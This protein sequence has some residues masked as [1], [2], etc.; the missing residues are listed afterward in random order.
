MRI[1]I[2]EDDL[3]QL[4]L[5]QDLGHFLIL[6]LLVGDV[7]NGGKQNSVGHTPLAQSHPAAVSQPLDTFVTLPPVDGDPLGD[8]VLA[9]D[10]ARFAVQGTK[11]AGAGIIGGGVA[12]QSAL[13]GTPIIMKDINQDALD[14]GMGE[15]S[16]LL[17]KKV[18][19]GH[20]AMDKMV[21]TLG[22]IKPTLN[23]ADLRC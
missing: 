14:L 3:D 22:K 11:H 10:I 4:R 1:L 5:F 13:K 9:R 7:L 23:D 2:V 12:Y 15:A 6:A 20:M 19:R 16:K 21:A 18:Q 17:G 8:P